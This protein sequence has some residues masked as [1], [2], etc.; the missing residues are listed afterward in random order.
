MARILDLKLESKGADLLANAL[1]RLEKSVVAG[2]AVGAVNKVAEDVHKKAIEKASR[3]I[4]LTSQYI[5]DNLKLRPAAEGQRVPTAYVSSPLR[6]VTLARFDAGQH[7]KPVTWS[8][9]R[10]EGMGKK[11]SAWPGW[12]R[13]TGDQA[14]GIAPDY[15]ASGI[16]VTVRRG[17]TRDMNSA[18]LVP[19]R[20]GGGRMGVFVHNG[21]RLK[22]LYG[23][24]VYQLY[25]NYV[26]D[27]FDNIQKELA[28]TLVA[29]L[30]IALKENLA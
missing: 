11:F 26:E 29:E 25:R 30:D 4:N 3:E 21:G 24:A 9:A 16:D 14:R 8:N 19:L 20:N 27:N 1:T 15:K 10:I 7:S 5:Q 18:F 12:T 28:D 22:H 6:N 17:Q 2:A 23:P 13:R